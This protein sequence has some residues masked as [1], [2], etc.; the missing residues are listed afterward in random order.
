MVVWAATVTTL[1]YT[2]LQLARLTDNR[3]PDGLARLAQGAG[4]HHSAVL[5]GVLVVIAVAVALAA[6]R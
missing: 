6:A 4:Q 2:S 5:A 3:L 1:W